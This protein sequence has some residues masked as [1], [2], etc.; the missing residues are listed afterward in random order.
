M[1]QRKR[2]MAEH[3]RRDVATIT[4]LRENAQQ[5]EA[6][7]QDLDLECGKLRVEVQRSHE[8]TELE[9]Y[10]AVAAESQKWEAQEERMIWQCNGS[11]RPNCYEDKSHQEKVVGP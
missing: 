6:H 4:K 2:G 7:S 1:W 10:C 9:C 5:Q 8:T 3:Q 11:R